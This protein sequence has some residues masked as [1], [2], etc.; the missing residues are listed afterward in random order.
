LTEPEHL[1]AVLFDDRRGVALQ[2][3]AERVIRGDEE[4]AVAAALDDRRAGAVG[5]CDGIV[6]PVQ[7][8]RSA[9]LAG[10]SEVA[11]PTL[12]TSL[13]VARATSCTARP[14]L[15][16]GTSAIICTPVAV[17]PLPG[18]RGAEVGLVLVVGADDFDLLAE[19]AAAVILDRHLR[20]R[21]GARPGIIGV[22][23]RHVGSG[24]R[25]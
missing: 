13:L 4:P 18:H 25:S 7:P 6:K 8:G 17:E 9:G 1:A 5:Q 15:E 10:Q 2:R 22:K 12:M 24:C 21:H 23:A 19:H 16:V 11:E 20:R 3:M 14:T